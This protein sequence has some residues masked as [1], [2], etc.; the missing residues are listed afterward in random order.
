MYIPHEDSNNSLNLHPK[1]ANS[2]Y[3]KDIIDQMEDIFKQLEEQ[4]NHKPTK[5]EKKA[6]EDREIMQAFF[7]L[8]ITHRNK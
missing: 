4:Q 6:Q 2:L 5:A 1:T 8:L 3:E 7:R